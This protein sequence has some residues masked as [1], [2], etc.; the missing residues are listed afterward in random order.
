MFDSDTNKINKFKIKP[1]VWIN[2]ELSDG[3]VWAGYGNG[4]VAILKFGNIIR[5]KTIL[6]GYK[7]LQILLLNWVI[8]NWLLDQMKMILFY[9]I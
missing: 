5:V 7:K 4:K 9:G 1:E 6:K 3:S 8:I 2:K